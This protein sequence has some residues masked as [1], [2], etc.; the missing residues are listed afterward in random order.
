M[1]L[2]IRQAIQTLAA[3]PDLGPVTIARLLR[4]F[5]GDARAV[6]SADRGALEAHCHSKQV[7]SILHWKELFDYQREVARMSD[8]GARFVLMEDN[9]Y[10][11][12]LQHLADAPPGLYH[13]GTLTLES[14]AVAVIGTR[15]PSVYG[16]KMARQFASGLAQAGVTVVSG[17]ARGIDTEAHAATLECGGKTMAVLGGGI[18]VIYPAENRGLYQ[19]LREE[20]AIWSEFPC[21]RQVDRQSFPQRNRLVSGMSDAVV[22]IESSEKG[23]SMITARFAL[24]QGKTVFAVPGRADS[25]SSRG[26]HQ[27]IR[28]GATLVESVDQL[29]EEMQFQQLDLPFLTPASPGEQQRPKLDPELGKI[30][31]LF[32]N[33]ESWN[34]DKV[35][36]ITGAPIWEVN[37]N[38]MRLE[39]QRCIVKRADGRYESCT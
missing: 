21:G 34:A 5:D 36:E 6:L 20:G 39:L 30:H 2:T 32:A 25:P 19:R 16:R 4:V 7:R 35:A 9:E 37:T 17:M 8:I 12:P 3:L 1:I 33:G 18:D 31:S 23:G 29:L 11:A 15:H 13:M 10:P 24:E 26:C 28:D 27:L 22:V 14:P 38:L